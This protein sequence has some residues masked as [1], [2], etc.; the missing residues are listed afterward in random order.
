MPKRLGVIGAGVI[1]LELGSVWRRLGRKSWCS[2]RSNVPADGRRRRREG[3][4]QAFQEAGPRHPPRRQGQRRRQR[5]G[6]RDAEVQR[7]QG[8]ADASRSTR[9]SSRSAAGRIRRTCSAKARA[10]SSTSAAS[11]KSTTTAS[12]D[13]ANVW[14]VGD[15]RARPDAGAQGQGRGRDGRRPDRRQARPK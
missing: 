6:R 15:L 14:A 3:S 10:C 9:S 12:T 4:A 1:G 5:Q 8:R 13:A 2:K 7:R 11:S